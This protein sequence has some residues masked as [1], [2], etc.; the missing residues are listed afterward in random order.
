MGKPVLVHVAHSF[1]KGHGGIAQ[2]AHMIAR[3]LEDEADALG[4]ELR[5][6]AFSAEEAPDWT[7]NPFYSAGGSKVGFLGRIHGEALL[8]THFLYDSCNMAQAHPR[9]PLLKKPNLTMIN[10]I[11]V[12]EQTKPR[13]L[14][15]ARES[16]EMVAISAHTRRKAEALHGGFA[17]AKVCLLGTDSD[18]PP[19]AELMKPARETNPDVLIVARLDASEDYKGHRELIACWPQVVREIPGA[20]LHIAGKG[21]GLEPTKKRAQES[22]VADHI[23]F[24]GFVPDADLLR[25]YSDSRILAMPSRGEG[26]GLVYT[27]AMRFR[28]PV[29]TSN[30]DAG[31]EIIVHGE[32]G[33]AVDLSND[34][35]LPTRIIGLLKDGELA[36]RMGDAGEQRWRET[37]TYSAFKKRYIQIVKE[38]LE[39]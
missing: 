4:V 9:I 5:R 15:A 37:F 29:I 8:G 36:T 21:T 33:Y 11:E 18:D 23:I 22:G 39:A 25:L 30:E 26:F 2:L 7:S 10:G 1:K 14:K 31:Q 3:A 24:H 28:R 38:F 27:D 32:T 16:S 34:K 17:R 12:W 20:K 13:W 19:P 35:D 6:V